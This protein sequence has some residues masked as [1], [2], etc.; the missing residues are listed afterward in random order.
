MVSDHGMATLGGGKNGSRETSCSIAPAPGS[1]GAGGEIR[2][3][4][5]IGICPAT[6]SE[7]EEIPLSP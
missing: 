2:V 5:R 7:Y 3:E 4:D 1:S 6:Y